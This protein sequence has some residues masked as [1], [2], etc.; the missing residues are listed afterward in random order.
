MLSKEQPQDIFFRDPKIAMCG[1]FAR[2]Y[3]SYNI[4]LKY[5]EHIAYL[6]PEVAHLVAAVEGAQALRLVLVT[7]FAGSETGSTGHWRC[8]SSLLCLV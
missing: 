3:Y 8:K 5:T 1:L 6:F 2:T 4:I 7:P